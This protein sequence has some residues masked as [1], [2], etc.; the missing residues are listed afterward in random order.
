MLSLQFLCF[1]FNYYIFTIL[2]EKH[3][4]VR[5]NFFRLWYGACMSSLGQ[6]W[7][8][9]VPAQEE[10]MCSAGRRNPARSPADTGRGLFP[11][12]SLPLDLWGTSRWQPLVLGPF[13]ALWVRVSAISAL[14]QKQSRQQAE[15]G[16]PLT[17]FTAQLSI[18]TTE[19]YFSDFGP[20]GDHIVCMVVLFPLSP[21]L[22]RDHIAPVTS[23]GCCKNNR[24][25]IT[26][27]CL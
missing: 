24:L 14:V 23:W 2:W 17:S 27:N 21:F 16:A 7:W 9:V 15:T 4:L 13:S 25:K 8:A 20:R 19:L 22:C 12:F 26:K 6:H 18:L 11:V 3:P 5:L 1:M 10:P